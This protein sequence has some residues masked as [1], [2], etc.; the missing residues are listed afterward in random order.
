VEKVLPNFFSPKIGSYRSQ[1]YPTN[2]SGRRWIILPPFFTTKKQQDCSE[3]SGQPLVCTGA[4]LFCEAFVKN[5]GCQVLQLSHVVGVGTESVFEEATAPYFVIWF[6]SR[7]MCHGY[8][9]WN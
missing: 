8:I 7:K 6:S 2:I 9:A 4:S 3:T 1:L 5:T